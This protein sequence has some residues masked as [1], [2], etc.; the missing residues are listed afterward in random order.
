MHHGDRA[1]D[2]EKLVYYGVGMEVGLLALAGLICWLWPVP[3]AEDPLR[4]FTF[5][6]NLGA[7]LAG[8]VAAVGMFGIGLLLWY[9][10]I[11]VFH[12]MRQFLM[13][14]MAPAISECQVWE[15]I[16][17]AISAGVGEEILF[18]GVLQPRIGWIA[19]AILFGLLHAISL[20]YVVVAFSLGA[21]LAWLQIWSGNLWTPIV[22]HAVYDY[23]MFLVLIRAYR[24]QQ[25]DAVVEPIAP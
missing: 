1:L 18:R 20:T 22:A 5:L 9:S 13:E 8:F 4:T 19:S 16:L 11:P 10:P 15:T 14:N 6:T 25:R 21:I 23:W 17:V 3:L 12:R 2:R 24:R 7:V